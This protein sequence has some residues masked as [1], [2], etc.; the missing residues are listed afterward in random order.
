MDGSRE[1][2]KKGRCA[3]LVKLVLDIHNQL[4]FQLPTPSSVGAAFYIAISNVEQFSFPSQNLGPPY[5]VRR[6]WKM[7]LLTYLSNVPLAGGLLAQLV[8]RGSKF[9]VNKTFFT[10][11]SLFCT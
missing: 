2:E 5:K 10:A 3:G 8:G 7:I 6:S 1:G 4:G 9:D 11:M